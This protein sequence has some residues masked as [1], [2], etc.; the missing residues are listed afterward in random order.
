MAELF[1]TSKQYHILHGAELLRQREDL[2][3]TQE[4]LGKL[5]GWTASH[6]CDLENGE[7]EVKERIR[8]IITAALTEARKK[9]EK[10][11][12]RLFGNII[13]DK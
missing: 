8:R 9:V 4:Q 11:K 1:T 2:G 3:L 6:I 7:R 12:K 5:C 10:K 13:E